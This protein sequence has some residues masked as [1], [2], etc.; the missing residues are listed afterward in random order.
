MVIFST[1][2]IG[3]GQRFFQRS[4]RLEISTV[5]QFHGRTVQ[6]SQGSTV[7]NNNGNTFSTMFNGHN[8]QRT[9]RSHQFIN[10]R[11][12]NLQRLQASTVIKID[13]HKVQRPHRSAGTTVNHNRKN[14]HRSQRPHCVSEYIAGTPAHLTSADPLRW[15]TVTRPRYQMLLPPVR[16][17][18]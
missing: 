1:D 16:K 11:S 18:E 14:G 7:V 13:G 17:H 9:Q 4:S 6:R 2:T 12:L 15:Q 5:P 8:V 10:Q 3:N